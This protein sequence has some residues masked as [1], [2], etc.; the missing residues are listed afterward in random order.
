MTCPRWQAARSSSQCDA[1]VLASVPQ[2]GRRLEGGCAKATMH[3]RSHGKQTGVLVSTSI[4][5]RSPSPHCS[6]LHVSPAAQPRYTPTPKLPTGWPKN[7]AHICTPYNYINF[8]TFWATLYIVSSGALNSTHSFTPQQDCICQ[9]QRFEFWHP[10]R[11]RMNY[12]A[13]TLPYTLL[14]CWS[15]HPGGS[16]RGGG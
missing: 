1:Y 9:D 14:Q 2:T 13:D 3:G 7:V 8:R 16:T 11:D 15:F 5:Q 6:S 10:D 4:R 12:V